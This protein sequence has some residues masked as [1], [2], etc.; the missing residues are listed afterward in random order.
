MK[1]D[2]A[3]TNGDF[4]SISV[5]LGN[6]DDTF[7]NQITHPTGYYPVSIIAGDFNNDM[8]LDLAVTNNG[9]DSISVLLGNGDGTFQNEITYSTGSDPTFT[10]TGSSSGQLLRR[11]Y[12]CVPG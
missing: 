9:D 2:L 4:N 5:L 8:K 12:Q 10:A 7:Q 3:V 11:Y 6:G 1:L